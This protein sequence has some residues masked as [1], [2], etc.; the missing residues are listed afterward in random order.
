MAAGS[1][2]IGYMYWSLLDNYEWTDGYTAKFGLVG[3]NFKTQDRIV[4]P[5]ARWLAEVIRKRSL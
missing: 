3:V 5:S 1:R 4:R 2:V